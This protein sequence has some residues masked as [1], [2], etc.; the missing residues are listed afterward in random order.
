MQI[1]DEMWEKKQSTT[2]C[3]ALTIYRN[4]IIEVLWEG[5]LPSI[6]YSKPNGA[7]IILLVKKWL[8]GLNCLIYE[9]LLNVLRFS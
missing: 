4:A 1:E 5:N 9:W 6:C 2:S 7:W 8:L 3:L